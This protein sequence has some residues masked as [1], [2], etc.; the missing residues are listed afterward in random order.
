MIPISKIPNTESIRWKFS[1]T[2]ILQSVVLVCVILYFGKTLFIPLSFSLLISFI[3][4]PVCKWMEQKGVSQ[5]I[6]ILIAIFMVL[7]ISS[8]I[9]YLLFLQI[10]EFLTEWEPFKIKLLEALAQVSVYTSEHFGI[11]TEEQTIFFKNAINN[12]G[13]ETFSAF[14]T[15]FYSLSGYAFFL[16]IIPVFSA[17]ILYHRSMLAEVLYQIFPSDKKETVHEVLVETISAYY[18]FI[19]GMAL[20]YL[21][22]GLLNS[23]GLAIIGIPHPFVFGF[24]ASI[25][26]FI[27][28]I[29]IMIS[30]L[31]PIAISWITFNSIWYPL[32]VILV[33]SIVQILEAYV[34]FP[35]AVGSRLK[36]NTLVI[37]IMI[38]AGGILWGAAGM[39]LFI[40]FISI[41]KLIAERTESLKTLSLLLGDGIHKKEKP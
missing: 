13:S 37:I 26:T 3:L 33:F 6:A 12:S 24:I 18:N 16:L 25:L 5:T 22:V 30:S 31:L 38:T 40:P 23:I 11:T 19:K 7:F 4:Y 17:L 2:K 1:T 32:G 36:I 20:V 29:G 14:K 28:Y 39:I 34:I 35:F 41:I 9:L 10:N 15:I 21:I 27:P 8:G